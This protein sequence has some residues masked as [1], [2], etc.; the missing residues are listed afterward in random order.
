[1]AVNGVCLTVRAHTGEGF[2][3]DIGPETA[4]V[5]TLG[6]ARQGQRMHLE[7]A[8]SFGGRLDGHLVTGHVDGVGQVVERSDRGSGIDLRVR[9]PESVRPFLI[10]KGSVALDG[11][12]LTLNDVKDG[13][14]RVT[15]VPHTLQKTRLGELKP[16]DEVNLEADLIGKYLLHFISPERREVDEA[17]L[18]EHGFFEPG[19]RKR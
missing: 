1:V 4:R 2:E 8:L 11:V 10:E 19:E 7:R 15:L 3:A 9:A 5:T 6:R 14:F 17:F 13:S 16:G 12:S 18:A